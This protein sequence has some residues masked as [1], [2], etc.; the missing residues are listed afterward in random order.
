ML[1]GSPSS[2]GN[3][4]CFAQDKNTVDPQVCE[5]IEA[6]FKKLQEAYN[7]HDAAAFAATYTQDA[8]E[9]TTDQGPLSG[10]EAI[11]KRHALDMTSFPGEL[12]HELL[13]VYQVG[14]E[15][16]LESVYDQTQERCKA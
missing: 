10:R 13:Q 15:W 5:E 14:I 11:E 16:L 6:V 3:Q 2:I 8:I 9:L 7:K 1:S 4:L 12:S